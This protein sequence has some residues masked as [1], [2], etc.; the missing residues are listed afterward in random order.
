MPPLLNIAVVG[1]LLVW[2]TVSLLHIGSCRWPTTVWSLVTLLQ[3]LSDQQCHFYGSYRSVPEASSAGISTV[4]SVS[5][6][7]IRYSGTYLRG[8]S[9]RYLTWVNPPQV[10]TW[11]FPGTWVH[12]RYYLVFIAR[13]CVSLISQMWK[14]SKWNLTYICI[15]WYCRSCYKRYFI[16]VCPWHVL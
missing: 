11:I 8:S 16:I 7:G 5:V 6:L 3:I 2:L 10:S 1:L 4:S 14:L 15:P 9:G 13:D 12:L